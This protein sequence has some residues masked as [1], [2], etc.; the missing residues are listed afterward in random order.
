MIYISDEVPKYKKKS[1][2][3]PP[4]KTGHKHTYKPCLIEYPEQFYL[5]EHDRNDKTR[6]RFASYCT[7]CGKVG[8]MDHDRW[9]VSVKHSD[10][11]RS[12]IEVDLT[13]EAKRELNPET[14]TL[15][16]FQADC[17]LPKFINI[18]ED[19]K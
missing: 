3:K 19:K 4:K 8:G 5:K 15:P 18:L 12:W 11:D 7:V 9:Y 13:D 10:G 1:K 17:W 6:L 2:V 16:V 14:R